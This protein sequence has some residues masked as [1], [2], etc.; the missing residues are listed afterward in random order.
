VTKR[1]YFTSFVLF[2]CATFVV[3]SVIELNWLEALLLILVGI[4][5]VINV[6]DIMLDI[7]V[8]RVRKETRKKNGLDDET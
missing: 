3:K 6:A 1:H 7:Y 8:K 2:I 4:V 5:C